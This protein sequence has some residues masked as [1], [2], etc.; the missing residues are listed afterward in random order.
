MAIL[1]KFVLFISIMAIFCDC[2]DPGKNGKNEKKDVVKQKVDET[3]VERASEM[4]KGKSIVM[5]DSKKEGT[6]T[7]KIPH[8]YGA[9]SGM[10]GQNA[11]P[12]ASQIGSPK[13]SP[14]GTQIGSP[15][16]IS[17]PKS[18]QIGSPK[19]IQ[20][21]SPRK[22]KTKLSSAVGSSDFNVIDE[23]KEAKK[24]SQFKPSPSRSQNKREQQRLNVTIGEAGRVQSSKR[25]SSKDT[26]SPSRKEKEEQMRRLTEGEENESKNK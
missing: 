1:L 8:R 18:T 16:S 3:K 25:V 17:S 9:V 14:K 15:R 20:I 5:A 13:N 22:E 23:S 24:P 2:M 6:T 10:S 21:G 11:S 19:G 12:E 7:V 4:N 26:F